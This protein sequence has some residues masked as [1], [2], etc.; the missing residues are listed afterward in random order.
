M[1][2]P[3]WLIIL[4][5]ILYP[6]YKTIQ[7]NSNPN[8]HKEHLPTKLEQTQDKSS[9][10]WED[11]EPWESTMPMKLFVLS[12]II[13]QGLFSLILLVVFTGTIFYVTFGKDKHFN[14][15]VLVIM[16]SG[17]LLWSIG[18]ILYE[19]IHKKIPS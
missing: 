16:I 17:L 7:S 15:I 5:I 19:K 13:L 6:I 1:F 14:N 2:I 10:K 12:K 11:L 9:V 8:T 4:I 3:I 18:A